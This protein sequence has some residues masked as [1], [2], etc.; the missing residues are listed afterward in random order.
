MG[1]KDHLQTG[2]EHVTLPWVGGRHLPSKTVKYFIEG[3]LPIEHGWHKF[4]VS[5]RKATWV[6]PADD[7]VTESLGFHVIGYI[8]GD[9]I[10]PDGIRVDPDVTKITS[11]SEQVHFL[12]PGLSRFARIRA[13]RIFAESPLFFIGEEMPIGPEDKVLEAW[14]D[15][16]ESVLDISGVTPALDVAFRMESWQRA[17]A[18]RRRA[19]IERLRQEEIRR[20]AEEER[21]NQ[22]VQQLGNAVGRREMARVDFQQAATAALIIGSAE[23]LDHRRGHTTDEMIVT[24]RLDGRRFECVCHKQT[25]RI[26]DSG[27]CLNGGGIRGDTFFTLESLPGVIRQAQREH[28]LHVFRHVDDHANDPLHDEADF[29]DNTGW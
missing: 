5:S 28:V 17:E 23:Y 27:I 19:E 8:V 12:D 3:R 9:R 11:S 20:L 24:F 1:W 26:I 4:K 6:K 29:D 7:V 22:L 14:Q 2:N 18:E 21:R 25:L 15:R 10:I 16:K 13:G